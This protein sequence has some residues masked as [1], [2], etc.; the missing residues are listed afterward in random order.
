MSEPALKVLKHEV[1]DYLYHND[2][3][4]IIQ[5]TV[6]QIIEKHW[7]KHAGKSLVCKHENWIYVWT[8]RRKKKYK[9][10]ED[11]GKMLT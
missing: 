11:C 2:C 4:P 10:C 5:R 3:P 6:L 9:F 1:E 7:I 8:F